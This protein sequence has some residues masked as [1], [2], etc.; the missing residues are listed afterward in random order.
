MNPINVDVA[1]IGAGTAGMGAYRAALSYTESVLLV[2]GGA[3]GTTCARVGCMPSKLLIAAA[4]AAHHARHTDPFGVHVE[5]V[6]VEGAAVMARVQRERDRFVGFVLETVESIPQTN[7][8]TAKVRFQSS[9]TLV[10]QQGQLI[11]AGRIVIASGSIPVLPPLLKGLGTRLL[12]NE[13]V[14]DLPT[15][16][17]SLAVFG[18]GVLGMELGQAMSRLGVNLKIFGIGGGIVGIRDEAMRA[19][20]NETFNEEFYLDASAQVKSVTETATGVD[21]YFL[22][23]DGTW[24]TESF[25]YVLAATG[26]AP[27]VAGLGLENTGLELNKWGVPIFNRFTMQCGNSAIFIAGDVNNEIPLLHEAADQGRIAGDNAGRY[28]D[29][30]VGLRRTPLAVA[31]TEPQVVSVGLNLEQIRQLYQSR[32]AVG[33]VSFE[34]QGRSRVMLR[35]KGML[36][37]YAELG[38]GLFLG[39]EMFGPSAEHIGHLMAWAAQKNMTVS[40]MLE[41]PFYH[42]VIEEGL[43]T[44]LRDLNHN[45][46]MGPGVIKRCLDCGP[47]A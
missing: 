40:E 27:N 15:L 47:G 41:M 16:P 19:Y 34:D 18:P 24:K 21:V 39:A 7:R 44:A 20:A 28:P 32:Y 37:V 10:T 5:R 1:I 9:N 22:H 38:S 17:K 8:L 30:R 31:F 3:Y 11:H 33:Q 25:E 26:R 4:E 2:E 6:S 35:N 45:L 36:K 42:P 13:S 43:R 29:L 12:T 46:H 23:Q 14:F